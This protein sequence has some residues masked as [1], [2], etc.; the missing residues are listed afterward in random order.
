MKYQRMKQSNMDNHEVNKIMSHASKKHKH[1]I[2]LFEVPLK[3]HSKLPGPRPGI[4]L[5]SLQ[6]ST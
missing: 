3:V 6:A 5:S 2:C 1:K 4:F